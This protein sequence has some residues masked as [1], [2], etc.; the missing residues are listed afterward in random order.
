MAKSIW[1]TGGLQCILTH[2]ITKTKHNLHR[3]AHTCRQTDISDGY[4]QPNMNESLIYYQ[5]N[6]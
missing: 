5:M 4:W 6:N 3:K 1:N 2:Y